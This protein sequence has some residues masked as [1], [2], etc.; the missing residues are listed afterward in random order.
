MMRPP[1]RRVNRPAVDV[2]AARK[3]RV[4]R[5]R[6]WKQIKLLTPVG[7]NALGR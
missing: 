7:R 2:I 4:E 1:N 5:E 3:M 6:Y